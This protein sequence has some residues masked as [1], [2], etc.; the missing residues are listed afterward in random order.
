MAAAVFVSW[1]EAIS[2]PRASRKVLS[3]EA[4]VNASLGAHLV[5]ISRF[6]DPS[7]KSHISTVSTRSSF[8]GFSLPLSTNNG[9]NVTRVSILVFL[10]VVRRACSLKNLHCPFE[11]RELSGV[12]RLAASSTCC[13]EHFR[14]NEPEQT[15][16]P[17][18]ASSSI[19]KRPER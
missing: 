8:F 17:G 11:N 7:G 3:S 13:A 2:T 16:P 6:R 9:P 5:E 12:S 1:P 19:L 10:P 15:K 18:L 4:A 14:L